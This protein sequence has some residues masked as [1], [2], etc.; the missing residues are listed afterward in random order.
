M[1]EPLSINH[2]IENLDALAGQEVSVRGIFR[3]QF[4]NVRIDH[5]PSAER[6]DGSASS[7]WF[8]VDQGSTN[9]DERVCGQLN[10]KR[11]T[12]RGTLIAGDPHM[13]RGHMGLWPAEIL[14]KAL[15]RG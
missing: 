5:Y 15:E 14:A 2:A 6:K 11:V 7:I 10:G 8:S 9:V 1:N 3:Y 4:E 12:V 13:G